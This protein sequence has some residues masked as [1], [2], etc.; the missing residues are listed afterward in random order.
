MTP[1]REA[2]YT[3][4]VRGQKGFNGVAILS[5]EQPDEVLTRFDDFGSDNEARTMAAHFR[6]T[7]IINTYVPQGR[8][9]E[10][11]AFAAKLKFLRD[12]R[13]LFDSRFGPDRPLLWVGD[14]NVAP[15][16]LDLFNPQS[17]EGTAGFHPDE[18]AILKE[19]ASWGFTDLFRKLYPELKQFT[20]WDYRLPQSFKRNLGWRIDHVMATAPLAT[21][22]QECS[23]DTEPRG[24]PKPSDHTPVVATFDLTRVYAV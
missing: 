1:L 15:E 11:P 4:Y 3:A 20:F 5:R 6:G 21:A 24:W 16:P 13:A 9:P 23:V 22:L 18:R 2:G 14:M 17:Y 12:L 7:W 8:S 19:V 10:D